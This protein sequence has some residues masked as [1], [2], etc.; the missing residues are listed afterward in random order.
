M[1]L[2]DVMNIPDHDD[3]YKE[4]IDSQRDMSEDEQQLMNAKL[5]LILANEVGDREKLSAAIKLAATR[6]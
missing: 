3:F 2:T 5:V 4:L 6:P 1:A